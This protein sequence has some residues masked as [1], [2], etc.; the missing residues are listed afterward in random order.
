MP[1][2]SYKKTKQKEKNKKKLKTS[3]KNVKTKTDLPKGQNL[4]D[5]N[6][7]VKKIVV[8]DQVKPHV[9][10]DILYQ[11]KL[12]A[13]ELTSRL[14]HHNSSIKREALDGLRELLGKYSADD[15]SISHVQL[16]HSVVRLALDE[17]SSIRKSACKIVAALLASTAPSKLVPFLD[18]LDSYL[19]CALTHIER[20]VRE[21][22]LVLLDVC[23]AH[24]PDM[25]RKRAWR[26][27]AV[28]LDLVSVKN[29]GART[30]SLNLDSSQVVTKWRI[31]V[32]E[33][34]DSLLA[35]LV[36][37]GDDR[38]NRADPC[39]E[40]DDGSQNRF[41]LYEICDRK[42]ELSAVNLE[43]EENAS[44]RSGEGNS[45]EFVENVFPL[46][47]DMFLE[48]CPVDKS[49]SDDAT[50][51]L[52]EENCKLL[53][54]VVSIV[55]VAWDLGG[56]TS[57]SSKK[58]TPALLRT[59]VDRRFPFG[60]SKNDDK[61]VDVN[62]SVA[63]LTLSI[64]GAERWAPVVPF[65]KNIFRIDGRLSPSDVRTF[66]DCV[67]RICLTRQ[68]PESE[69]FLSKVV[70]TCLQGRSALS[71]VF[72]KL[73][74]DIA[75]DPKQKR[76]HEL[77]DFRKWLSSLPGKLTSPPVSPQ[78][79]KTVSDIS[80][81]GFDSFSKSLDDNIELILDVI[82][83]VGDGVKRK[84]MQR[85]MATLLHR[86]REWDDEL[87]ESLRTAV[88]NRYWG[89]QL[90]DYIADIVSMKSARYYGYSCI[91]TNG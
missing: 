56:K 3:L 1:N 39:V 60:C 55:Q 57:E 64:A 78:Q 67:S 59:L 14:G 22:G 72:F 41:P 15:L 9:S 20:P 89:D 83:N 24:V 45:A 47:M 43:F 7:K 49:A 65:L 17:T 63:R 74:A 40:Y 31:G 42:N 79:V 87:V 4:T 58:L 91:V 27:I 10:D 76:F 28:C 30:L 75:L 84:Q 23:L 66:S 54:L 33:R 25:C 38:A 48:V 16:L 34:I 5:T 77:A 68:F 21:D 88:D 13:A 26:L 85:Q 2:L 61:S 50:T 18:T 12:N 69:Y 44:D 35:L 80:V 90:T 73:L 36:E 82:P 81:R 86:V 8:R 19:L 71:Q 62:L 52:S 32:L 6:F 51:D 46:L 70:T 53:G 11:R 37:H 29:V